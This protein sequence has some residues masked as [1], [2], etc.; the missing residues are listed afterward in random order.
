M[1]NYNYFIGIDIGKST[2]AVCVIDTEENRRLECNIPNTK[3]GMQTLLDK[4]NR[5]PDFTLFCMEHTGIVRH[6]VARFEYG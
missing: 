6:E 2:N 3:A 4:L 5:L 1:A